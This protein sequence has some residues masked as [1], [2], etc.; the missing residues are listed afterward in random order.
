MRGRTLPGSS[1]LRPLWP[2]AFV[3]L[4]SAPVLLELRASQ[5][6]ATPLPV[7]PEKLEAVAP[8]GRIEAEPRESIALQAGKNTRA[9]EFG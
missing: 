5:R 7:P 1:P 4:V 6:T 8:P 2:G 9:K 3:G